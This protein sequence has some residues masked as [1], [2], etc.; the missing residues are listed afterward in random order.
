MWRISAITAAIV[1]ILMSGCAGRVEVDNN[2]RGP[3]LISAE[4]A[5]Y[6]EEARVKN[7]EGDVWVK[8]RVNE[9]GKVTTVMIEKTPDQSLCAAAMDAALRRKYSPAMLDGKPVG[10]W[11]IIPI[12]VKK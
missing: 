4:E 5:V 10:V 3:V 7:V 2:N 11:L 6:P 1:A 9:N 8:M 12:S